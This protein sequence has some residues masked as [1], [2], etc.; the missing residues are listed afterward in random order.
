MKLAIKQLDSFE[1][2]AKG[3]HLLGEFTMTPKSEEFSTL[4]LAKNVVTLAD[5]SPLEIEAKFTPENGSFC[6]F[7]SLK[8]DRIFNAA[9]QYGGIPASFELRLAENIL[10]SFGV[11]E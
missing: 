9:F 7:A 2:G 3:R 10:L 1:F 11:Q 4:H 6:L 8:G 5:G